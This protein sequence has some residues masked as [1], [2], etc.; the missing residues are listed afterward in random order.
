M[1][2]SVLV[3]ACIPFE[4]YC[5]YGLFFALL[6]IPSLFSTSYLLIH[7][8]FLCLHPPHLGMHTQSLDQKLLEK[9]NLLLS[10]ISTTTTIPCIRVHAF[11]GSVY[12]HSRC[13]FFLQPFLLSLHIL[14]FNP[15]EEYF[16]THARY[17]QSILPFST[18]LFLETTNVF[19][20]TIISTRVIVY[21][22]LQ[23]GLS[24]G[25]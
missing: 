5:V 14:L 15:W 12:L 10:Y 13:H 21:L 19:F 4:F 3:Y 11:H 25:I 2:H 7:G 1:V 16:Y 18:I 6:Y 9:W 17:A 23:K 20:I 22:K 8:P 24:Q